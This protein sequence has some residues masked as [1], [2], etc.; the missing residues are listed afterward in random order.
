MKWVF[1]VMIVIFEIVGLKINV[2]KTVAMV[3]QTRYIYGR[4]SNP[5]FGW[6]MTGDGDSHCSRQR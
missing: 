2:I 5:E 6:R 4:H 3:C 1:D